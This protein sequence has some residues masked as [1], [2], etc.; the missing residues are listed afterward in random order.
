MA[1]PVGWDDERLVM[2]LQS[3]AGSVDWPER[4]LASAVGARLRAGERR[5]L[6][7]PRLRLVVMAVAVVLI[8][9]VVVA[10]IPRPRHAVADWL[11]LGAVKVTLSPTTSLSVSPGQPLQLGQEMTLPAA[12]KAVG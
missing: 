12:K 2:G 1:E 10:G 7:V 9:A 3:L 11:G 6:P 5:R 4:D 8:A